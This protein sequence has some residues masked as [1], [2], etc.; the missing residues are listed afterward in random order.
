MSS[1]LQHLPE[2]TDRLNIF[3]KQTSLNISVSKTQVT[4]INATPDVPITVN[5]NPLG[6][7]GS[8]VSKV[9]ATQKDIRAR[10]GKVRGVFAKLQSIW[11]SKQYSLRTKV[12][13]YNRNVKSGLLYGSESWRVV[14]GNMDPSRRSVASSDLK[15]LK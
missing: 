10:L 12:R 9:N 6:N 3:V 7:L 4:C 8:L 2:K 5:G 13:L 1:K 11:K 15:Y 14:K